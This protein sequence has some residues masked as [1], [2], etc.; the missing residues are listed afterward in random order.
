[1]AVE[2]GVQVLP[3]DSLVRYLA[4]GAANVVYRISPPPTPHRDD[5]AGPGVN[6][7][8]AISKGRLLRLRKELHSTVPYE[9]S[10][11]SFHDII[12]PLFPP[13]SLV[14]H[15]LV[16]LPDDFIARRNAELRADELAGRRKA[17]RRSL[18]LAGADRYGALITDMSPD[19]GKHEVLVDF[20][21]KWLAQSASAPA[22]AKRCRTCALRARRNAVRRT[23]GA[24]AE[25]SFCPLDL[26]SRNASHILRAVRLILEESHGSQHHDQ[27]AL[28]RRLTSYLLGHPVLRRLRELQLE[29]DA[30]GVL[31]GDPTS[32]DFLLATTLRDCTM[33]VRVPSTEEGKLVARLADLDLKAPVLSKIEHWRDVE[34]G[35]IDGGWYTAEEKEPRFDVKC[36]LSRDDGRRHQ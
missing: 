33:L 16:A 12:A 22:N 11:R 31:G 36:S 7:H 15:D 35:L 6:G 19:H 25:T 32:Q 27:G 13:Q 34:R 20:K 18:Y 26:V 4:E 28:E 2:C 1:M 30:R 10:V 3:P 17:C 21:P 14:D 24:P 5:D 8:H 29:L 9:Q 23:K